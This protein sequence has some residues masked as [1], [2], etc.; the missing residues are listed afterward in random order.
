[1]GLFNIFGNKD[2]R[3]ISEST[4]RKTIQMQKEMNSQTLTQLNKYGVNEDSILRLEFFFYTDKEDKASNLAIE[5]K[6]LDYSI[7]HVGAAADDSKLWSVTG[8][9][10]PMKMNLNSVT[11]WTEDMCRIA[12]EHDCEFDGW[13]T[14]PE[15]EDFE[16]EE[17]LTAEEYYKKAT[18]LLDDGEVNKAEAYFTKSIELEKTVPLAY[19]GRAYLKETTG[20]KQE[21]IEDYTAALTITPTFYEALE[22]RGAIKDEM[23][24]YDGAIA[25]YTKSIEINPESAI[26]YLNRGN[27]KY[28]KGD[29]KGACE[30]WTKAQNLGDETARENVKNYCK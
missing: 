30:D 10:T 26:S 23:G 7:E 14:S 22:N 6:E 19:Y 12:F 4:F 24:D 17:G 15:Q 8:W 13:G 29:K 5:L 27:S 3:Y 21:A 16:V 20:R 28:H 18:K 9:S 1:M 25:D 2:N 11:K